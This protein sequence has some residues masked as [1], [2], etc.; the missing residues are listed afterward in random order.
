MYSQNIL[1]TSFDSDIRILLFFVEMK[2][3]KQVLMICCRQDGFQTNV[4]D[5]YY[6]ISFIG[7]FSVECATYK[8]YDKKLGSIPFPKLF[9]STNINY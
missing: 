3:L 4:Q 5:L 6:S 9:E 1:K 7:T 2:N 8:K